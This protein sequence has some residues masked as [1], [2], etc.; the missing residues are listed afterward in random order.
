M[1]QTAR[2]ARLL[3]LATAALVAVGASRAGATVLDFEDRFDGEI[4][5]TQYSGLGVTF[6]NGVILKSGASLND[7]DFPPK[8]GLFI[9]SDDGGPV[10]G[11]FAFGVKSMSFFVTYNTQL[12]LT[13]FDSGGA[14]LGSVLSLYTDNT[15]SSG[16]PPNELMSYECLSC[17]GIRSF[18]ITGI[19]PS[20]AMDD[21]AFVAGAPTCPDGG[22]VLGALGVATTTMWLYRRRARGFGTVA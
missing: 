9:A 21:F 15:V 19:A 3:A 20:F 2:P 13:L 11:S 16:N 8:S 17:G 12:T 22:S 10:T 5:T 7:L 6:G 1:L 4:L 14:T 18:E